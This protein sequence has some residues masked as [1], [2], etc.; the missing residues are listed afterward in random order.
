MQAAQ[1]IAPRAGV[2]VLHKMRLNANLPHLA[3][4]KTLQKEAPLVAEYRRLND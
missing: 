1:Y 3:L 4:V 2:V